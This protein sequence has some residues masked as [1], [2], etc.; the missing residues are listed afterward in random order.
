MVAG[1]TVP[2]F[3]F[4]TASR[5]PFI[6]SYLGS[7]SGMAA[8]NSLEQQKLLFFHNISIIFNTSDVYFG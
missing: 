1:E 2:I 5:W 3:C 8:F 7:Q 4:K 6:F